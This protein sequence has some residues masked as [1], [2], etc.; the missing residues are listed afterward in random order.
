M[1]LF[2]KIFLWSLTLEKCPI[3][4]QRR[5]RPRYWKECSNIAKHLEETWL[6][7]VPF[8]NLY[9][10][11]LNNVK[12]NLH[13]V[14]CMSPIGKGFRN[15]LRMFPSLVNCCTI[16][17]FTEWPHDAL[18]KVA[19]K[20]L[21]D[22]VMD[23]DVRKN[24][25]SMCSYF[26]ESVRHMSIK[27]EKELKRH[28]YVTP[29]SYLALIWTF[30]SLLTGKRDEILNLKTRYEMG[31]GKLEFASN[32]VS[33]MQNELTDLRPKLLETSDETEKLMIKIEQ[34]TIQVEAKKE[35]V[36]C[37]EAL[38]NEAAAAAQAIRDDCENDLAEAIPELLC[39]LQS[40]L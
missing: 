5:K 20:F 19:S 31:L 6:A 40:T 18:E 26:H 8:A 3:F 29:T 33:A 4:S 35:I 12:R 1:K 28:N 15:R 13:I 39:N 25:V 27:Y 7:K 22:M 10:I 2:L 9:G 34:D 17:W 30:K 38:A 21:E 16:D 14:L 24:C 32:Q 36:A 37:D 11:F 23:D